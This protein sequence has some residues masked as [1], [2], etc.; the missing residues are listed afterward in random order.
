MDEHERYLAK[1][2]IS[3]LGSVNAAVFPA[4]ARATDEVGTIG[5]GTA[6]PAPEVRSRR[7][8][9]ASWFP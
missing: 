1:P 5:L 9:R 7:S 8:I 3:P 6:T 4:V 2:R